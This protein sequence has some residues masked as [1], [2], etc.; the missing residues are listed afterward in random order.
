MSE[1]DGRRP[2][3]ALARP[4]GR[5]TLYD[6]ELALDILK[7][8]A[9]GELLIDICEDVFY[10]ADS[11]VRGWAMDDNWAIIQGTPSPAPG[12]GEALH[13]AQL[14]GIQYELEEVRRIA[15]TPHVGEMKTFRRTLSAKDGISEVTEV[16]QVE[17]TAHRAMRIATRWKRITTIGRQLYGDSP[18]APAR[19]EVEGGDEPARVVIIGG[20]PDDDG[21]VS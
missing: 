8:V 18:A 20:L 5:P 21:D 3:T 1:G 13:R 19:G 14:L 4:R 7:R 2:S 16:R 12:F 6:P 10:P 11:T 17:M 15:D 9:A